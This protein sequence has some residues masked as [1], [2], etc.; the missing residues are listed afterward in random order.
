MVSFY[1]CYILNCMRCATLQFRWGGNYKM[2]SFY[3]C[4]TE[5]YEVCHPPVQMGRK[6]LESKLLCMLH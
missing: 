6:L 4:Y 2:V 5:L 1:V 3:V